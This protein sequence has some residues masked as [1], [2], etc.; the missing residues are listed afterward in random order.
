MP[1]LGGAVACI[2][3]VTPLQKQKGN[4]CFWPFAAGRVIVFLEVGMTAIGLK[5][6]V[7]IEYFRSF[8]RPLYPR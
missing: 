8:E 2:Q 6:P 3:L 5:L 1:S 4:V 7:R